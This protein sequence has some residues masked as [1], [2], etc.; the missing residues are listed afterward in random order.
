MNIGIDLDNTLVDYEAAFRAAAETLHIAL[1]PDVQ[2]KTQIRDYVRST[3]DG[4]RTWQRLQG[5]AYGRCVQAHAKL[6]PGVKRFLWRCRQ[7]GHRVSIISHKT[8]FGH[9]DLEKVPLREVASE[10]LRAQGLVE[11]DACFVSEVVYESS[12]DEKIAAIRQHRFDWFID[13]LAEVVRDLERDETLRV[14]RFEPGAPSRPGDSAESGAPS[15][16][17]WQ[18]IDTLINGEWTP[19]EIGRLARDMMNIEP[20]GI[21]KFSGGN[22]GVYRIDAA[23][24][25]LK[26]KVYPVDV[27]HDRLLSE[28]TATREMSKVPGRWVSRPLANDAELGVGLYEWID[29]DRVGTPSER[30]LDATLQFL[31]A[32]HEQRGS[33]GFA[34]APLASAACFSGDDI[35]AQL[36]HRLRQ[37]DG[38]RTEHPAL[39]RFLAAAFEPAMTDLLGSAREK[40][41]SDSPF[42]K[43]ISKAQQ[44]L[45]PSDF[46]FHNAIRRADGSLAFS[47]FEYFGWDD[48]VKLMSDFTLHPGMSLSDDQKSRWLAGA[49]RIYGQHLA[50][51]LSVCRPLYGL[52]W[53]LILLNHFRPEIWQRRVLADAGARATKDETLDRQLAKAH[54]LLREIR[55]NHSDLI[56]ETHH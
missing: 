14:V 51:R 55:L 35:Q 19:T 43:R 53:C 16:S 21:E 32:L 27:N 37:F 7:K 15:L 24:A 13:D 2:S 40:W 29:G 34:H 41:P 31:S 23:S 30:D 52:I 4:E 3:P 9:G 50:Q 44:T 42:D 1:L 54:A 22:A 8:E 28:L 6:Y 45:S 17:D 48:P 38:P 56:A 33:P 12:Y 39:E 11:R 49:L 25:S 5:L 46:G 26:L 20:S 18:Q 36:E 10:F 47:D